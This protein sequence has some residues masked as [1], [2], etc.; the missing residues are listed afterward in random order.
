M[1]VAINEYKKPY[2]IDDLLS[3]VAALRSPGG[4]SW[5][6]EQTHQSIRNDFL[7]ECY[8][9]VE[10][11]D[12]D[13]SVHMREELGDVL[14][15]VVFHARIEEEKGNFSFA[16][17][18]NDVTDKMIVRHPHV[19]GD[20]KADTSEEVLANW[21]I[22]KKQTRGQKT[23]L[24]M[25]MSISK[26][27]PALMRCRKVQKKSEKLGAAVSRD[28]KAEIAEMISGGSLGEEEIGKLLFLVTDL[29]RKNGVD[30]ENSLAKYT[31]TFIAER[32]EK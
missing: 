7:E 15:Q 11:I 13:D 28:P 8:E 2:T 27:M 16:D 32:F 12:D 19:F 31:D 3:I 24:E 26:A 10:T 23:D 9:A 22:I 5:D 1:T 20:V 6:I 17:V 29:A 4:C 21:D 25:L 18:V 30:A 14:F